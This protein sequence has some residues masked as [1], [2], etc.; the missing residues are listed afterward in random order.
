MK[1]STRPLETRNRKELVITGQVEY[2]GLTDLTVVRGRG[3]SGAATGGAGDLT[4]KLDA[5]YPVFLH[6][7]FTVMPG[8]GGGL[9]WTVTPGLPASYD[10]VPTDGSGSEI[11]IQLAD[12]T[13]ATVDP[14]VGTI[15]SFSLHVQ[16]IAGE[17]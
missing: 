1:H 17:P 3:V 15:L 4:I 2:N 5:P 11:G 6:G 10:M 14:Q 8:P 16:Q 7:T 12:S 13:G 9:G